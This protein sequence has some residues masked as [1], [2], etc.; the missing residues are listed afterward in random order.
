MYTCINTYL[1]ICTCTN[2]Y[3]W[4]HILR[5]C[6]V[7]K[8]RDWKFKLSH[9]FD[10]WQAPQ[11][12]SCWDACKISESSYNSK[13]KSHGFWDFVRSYNKASYQILKWGRDIWQ[14]PQQHS[15]W[16][17]CQISESSYNSKYKSH[18]FWDFVRSYNKASYQI[19]KW[20]RALQCLTEYMCVT[21]LWKNNKQLDD[22]HCVCRWLYTLWAQGIHRCS[23]DQIFNM[24]ET[25]IPMFSRVHVYTETLKEW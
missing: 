3:W 9:R 6:G 8:L 4:T 16:D 5:S 20:G 1:C 12:H 25:S 23:E 13:Y 22:Q 7:L 15:C 19:L 21:K 2:T 24:Y 10:I 17:A 18:G 14:A 11:Q